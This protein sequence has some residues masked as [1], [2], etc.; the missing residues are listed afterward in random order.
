MS[1]YDEFYL[2]FV[3]RTFQEITDL[4]SV[5]EGTIVRTITR[6]DEIIRD[7]R[8]AARLI[9]SSGLYLKMEAASECIR[10]DIIFSPSLYLT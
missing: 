8:S 5:Q 9:G 6:L 3:G 1:L 2:T 7:F 4:T 10:R